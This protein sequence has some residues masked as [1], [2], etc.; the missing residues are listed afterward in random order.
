M[1]KVKLILD[2]MR[3]DPKVSAA[4]IAIQLGVSSRSVEKRIRHMRENGIIRRIGPDKGG[5]W[6]LLITENET[7]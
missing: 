7:P 1:D 3:Q 2:A 5:F 4:K 6:E